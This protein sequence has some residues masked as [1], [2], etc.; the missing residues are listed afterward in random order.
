VFEE[1]SAGGVKLSAMTSTTKRILMV[2]FQA[3]AVMLATMAGVLILCSLAPVALAQD[4][5]RVQTNQVLV[6]SN[7]RPTHGSK[8]GKLCTPILRYMNHCS[9]DNLQQPCK[10]KCALLT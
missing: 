1:I 3:G 6:P 5:I 8:E 7:Q 4:P 9:R 10:F 2:V